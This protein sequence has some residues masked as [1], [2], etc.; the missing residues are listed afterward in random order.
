MVGT[1]AK[2][3]AIGRLP[4]PVVAIALPRPVGSCFSDLESRNIN[5][6]R[7]IYLCLGRTRAYARLQGRSP[8]SRR[9]GRA[10]TAV[11]H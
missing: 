4:V 10:A 5:Q 1:F 3:T 8:S 11:R 9:V 6:L 2:A 7:L